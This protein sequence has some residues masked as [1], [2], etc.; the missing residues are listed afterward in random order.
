[1]TS[2]EP[3]HLLQEQLVLRSE[4]IKMTHDSSMFAR[5][6]LSPHEICLLS[7]SLPAKEDNLNR[8]M[9]P[10]LSRHRRLRTIVPETPQK[11]S[12]SASPNAFLARCVAAF[13]S[14]ITNF[15]S[16][17]RTSSIPLPSHQ[18]QNLSWLAF[19]IQRACTICR[20]WF[21]ARCI[22]QE[23]VRDADNQSTVVAL[24]ALD[25]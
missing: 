22:Y 23:A 8:D 16:L 20:K 5:L 13:P 21:V 17:I 19:P 1:M 4:K 15:S 12:R 2:R 6:K 11:L 25:W 7:S 24:K 10:S 18:F 3:S 14:S 9:I